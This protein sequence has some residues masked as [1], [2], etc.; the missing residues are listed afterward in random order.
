MIEIQAHLYVCFSNDVTKSFI[1]KYHLE[2][3]IVLVD[4]YVCCTAYT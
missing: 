1:N 3:D 4:C 2:C